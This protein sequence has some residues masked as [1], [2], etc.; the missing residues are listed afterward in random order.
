[1]QNANQVFKY[2]VGQIV[3]FFATRYREDVCKE[4]GDS[5]TESFVVPATGVIVARRY[6]MPIRVQQIEPTNE[7]LPDGSVVHRPYSTAIKV[8]S[9]EPFYEIREQ[10]GNEQTV[11]EEEI[12]KPNR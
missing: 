1:M 3:D 2:S 5:R 6:D 11:H 4:C 10:S 12:I 8:I 7:T 9:H